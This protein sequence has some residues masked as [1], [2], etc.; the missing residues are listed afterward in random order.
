MFNNSLDYCSLFIKAGIFECSHFLPLL[1]LPTSSL[2]GFLTSWLFGPECWSTFVWS[3]SFLWTNHPCI[4]NWVA[5]RKLLLYSFGGKSQIKAEGNVW[6]QVMFCSLQKQT[7]SLGYR[8]WSS[9]GHNLRKGSWV[10]SPWFACSATS[11]VPGCTSLTCFPSLAMRG[12][13]S[14][15]QGFWCSGKEWLLISTFADIRAD[16]YA[17]TPHLPSNL[18]SILACSQ[19][20]KQQIPDVCR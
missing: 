6:D 12:S 5:H 17:M 15:G 2:P 11:T 20:T 19:P 10:M 8:W 9:R 13:N 4:V 18:H 1:F 7:A 14:T 16:T 3:H